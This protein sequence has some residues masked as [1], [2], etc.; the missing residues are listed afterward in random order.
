ML[1]KIHLWYRE[2]VVLYGDDWPNIEQYVNQKMSDISQT[3]RVRLL[4]EFRA[5]QPC[6]AKSSH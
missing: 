6:E 2:A 3:D 1:E 5:I 4:E